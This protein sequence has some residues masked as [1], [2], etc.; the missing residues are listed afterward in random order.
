V[1]WE[2]DTGF[3]VRCTTAAAVALEACSEVLG[4]DGVRQSTGGVLG[5]DVLNKVGGDEDGVLHL[6][7]NTST[8]LARQIRVYLGGNH[9]VGNVVD[10]AVNARS[11]LEL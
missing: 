7:T 10:G 3:A 1:A 6:P 9:E 5:L 11:A 4:V 2:R 8:P